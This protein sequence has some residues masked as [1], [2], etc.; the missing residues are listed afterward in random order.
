M[1]LL[2]LPETNVPLK[3]MDILRW[4]LKRRKTTTTKKNIKNLDCHCILIPA[5]LQIQ[6]RMW[7]QNETPIRHLGLND[8]SGYISNTCHVPTCKVTF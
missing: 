8:N 1:P 6:A 5:N 3:Y 2:L 4:R 7:E